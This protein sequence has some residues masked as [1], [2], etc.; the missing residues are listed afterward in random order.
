MAAEAPQ[1]FHIESTSDAVRAVVI[2]GAYISKVASG[3]GWDA[4]EPYVHAY[5]AAFVKQ[6]PQLADRFAH[7]ADVLIVVG[8]ML[9]D[10]CQ[11]TRQSE[12]DRTH[13]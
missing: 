13:E 11:R 7:I 6:A 4:A 5:L 9:R 1:E 2:G 10:E 12:E 8:Q 3:F